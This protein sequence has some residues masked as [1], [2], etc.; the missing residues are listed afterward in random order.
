MHDE[1]LA[2]L[3]SE[4]PSRIAWS[5]VRAADPGVFRAAAWGAALT[6]P[7]LA[8]VLLWTALA[9]EWPGTVALPAWIDAARGLLI[10]VT[11]WGALMSGI[12][13]LILLLRPSDLRREL[14]FRA[15]AERRGLAYAPY[16]QSPATWGVHFTEGVPRPARRNRT[17]RTSERA[18]E[19]AEAAGAPRGTPTPLFRAS[20][21]LSR[22]AAP[23]LPEL[24][25]AVYAYSGGKTD[26]RGPRSA[27]RALV[28]QLPRTLPHLMIDSR[29]NGSLRQ[30]L[31]GRLRLSLEGDFDRFFTVYVPAGYDRDAL[32]LLTPDVMAGLIDYGRGWDIEVVEDRLIVVSHRVG[33]SADRSDATA[34]LRF[35]EVV[36]ADLSHQAA[37]YTDP[38]SARPSVDV[39]VTG[40]R[41]RRRSPVG[42]VVLAVGLAAAFLAFPFVLG[43]VLDL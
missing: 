35:A 3:R 26:P 6:I 41:L 29:A 37:T 34:M 30:H 1:R 18:A 9:L 25:V 32:E 33:R 14:A 21:V 43:W 20:F 39:A 28:L 19:A 36:G 38:R 7:S 27:F 42:A 11:F 31:P 22:G 23:D 12:F 4:W 8:L 2:R 5:T 10:V 16:G 17:R 40:R 15:F 24:Q 13:A